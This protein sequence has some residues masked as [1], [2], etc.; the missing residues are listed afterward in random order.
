ML[1]EFADV[2]VTKENITKKEGEAPNE[3]EDE[4]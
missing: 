1:G 2:E 4:F 3:N